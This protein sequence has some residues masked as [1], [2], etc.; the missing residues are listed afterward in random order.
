MG[1]TGNL[2]SEVAPDPTG[3]ATPPGSGRPWSTAG[4]VLIVLVALVVLGGLGLFLFVTGREDEAR[5]PEFPSLAEHPDRSLQGAVASLDGKV[6]PCVRVMTA[7]GVWRNQDL[8]WCAPGRTL[9]WRDDG[10]LEHLAY[11]NDSAKGKPVEPA[12]RSG[13]TPVGGQLIDVRSGTVGTIAASAMP[14]TPPRPAD[15]TVG[16]DGQRAV[17]TSEDG[18]AKVTVT[19]PSG[20][21]TVMTAEGGSNYGVWV[22]G[23][24]PDGRWL[25]LSDG[26]RDVGTGNRW[27]ITTVDAPTSTRVLS[28]GD[29]EGAAEAPPAITGADVAPPTR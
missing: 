14:A 24:S 10:R 23:W 4:W 28:A 27:L 19:G 8:Q 25:L 12:A 15:P 13:G 20:T 9:R 22:L 21:R 11:S 3:E 16:P 7:S 5:V 26:D 6:S 17:A 18:R 2:G 1:D 29:V